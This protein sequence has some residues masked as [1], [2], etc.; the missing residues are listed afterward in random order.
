MGSTRRRK[1]LLSCAYPLVLSCVDKPEQRKVVTRVFTP[2]GWLVGTLHVPKASSLSDHLNSETGF[3]TFTEVQW[4]WSTTPLSFLALRKQ[5]AAVIVADESELGAPEPG[6]VEHQVSCLLFGGV[7]MGTLRLPAGQRVSDRL[8][9]PDQVF[10]L[11][12]CTIAV[13]G[14]GGKKL[15]ET[16]AFALINA[17]R[18]VGVAES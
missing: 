5:A 7:I 9:Q 18:L 11:R 13:D 6:L 4:P 8:V 15:T 12:G 3:L 1:R 16:A 10:P 2:T 17:N 14:E